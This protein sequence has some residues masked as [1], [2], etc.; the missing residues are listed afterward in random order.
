MLRLVKKFG[1]VS[2]V[3]ALGACGGS[4]TVPT[5]YQAFVGTDASKSTVGGNGIR[6]NRLVTL[7][8]DY[9]HKTGS[10]PV[11]DGTYSLSD[12]NGF[13]AND[14]LTDGTSTLRTDAT[15]FTGNYAF[16]IP[17]VQTNAGGSDVFGVLGLETAA[18]DLPQNDTLTF[19]GEAE[20]VMVTNSSGFDLT[21][22][23]SQVI[24]NFGAGAVTVTLSDFIVT[25][26][27]TGS[28]VTNQLDEISVTNMLISD[29]TFRN[30]TIRTRLNGATVDILGTNAQRD[31]AGSFFGISADGTKP[32]E[33]GGAILLQGDSG[34]INGL[35]IANTQ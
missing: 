21:D 4:T 10:I 8:G 34:L 20:G 29:N 2:S 35:F 11:A 15:S 18:I 7:S 16:A 32:R 28:V 5:D 24:A 19:V 23:T 33:V 22:G 30:G 14:A 13:D 25:D 26:Q 9:Q 12:P 17:F 6:S 3:L 1:I 31:A 27:S